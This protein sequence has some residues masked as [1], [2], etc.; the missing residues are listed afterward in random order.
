MSADTRLVLGA[1]AKINLFLRVLAREEGGYHQLETLFQTVALSDRLTLERTTRTGVEL[2]VV[3]AELGPPEENLAWRA[4]EA[5]LREAA[6]VPGPVGGVRIVLEKRI[7]HGAGLGGGSSDA[8]AVLR[9]V[10]QL[11]GDPLPL[12]RLLALAASL[13]SDVPVFLSPSPTT[14]AWGRGE[15]LL[16]L[17][18]LPAA[19]I[20]L[21]IPDFPVSTP[22]AYR[23]LAEWRTRGAGQGAGRRGPGLLDPGALSTWGGVAVASE[24]D[25][26]EPVFSWHPH[27]GEIRDGLRRAGASTALLSGSGAALFGVFAGD[28]PAASAA[29]TL[30]ENF[31]SVRFVV[32]RSLTVP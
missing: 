19:P 15:R 16:P 20:L 4:A 24:N 26:E 18:P 11:L 29:E 31:P 21:A 3:G 8:A 32:T 14:L 23:R 28:R 30:R 13:G 27:L 17:P 7:P 2:E 1:P 10:N 25:F 6:E 12:E 22:E 9:G 5:V